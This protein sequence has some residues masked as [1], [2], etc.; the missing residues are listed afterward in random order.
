VSAALAF[1]KVNLALV[2]GPSL[3]GGKHEVLT[4]LQRVEL[5]DRLSLVPAA[6]NSV[7]GFEGDTLGRAAL[8]S[9]ASRVG[10]RTGW[11]LRIDK[12]I[13]VASGLGGGSSDAAAALLLAN[14]TLDSPLELDELTNLARALGADVPFFLRDGPQLG[15]GDG[16]VLS[17]LRLPSDYTVL[18]VLADGATKASTGAVYRAFDDRDGAAGFS[19][20]RA[21]LEQA[22]AG[23]SEALD[24]SS[25]PPNDLA[26]SP[27]A[28]ELRSL[29]AFR[30]DVSGAGPVVYGLF[31]ERAD[32]E[33]AALLLERVGRTW[34]T[35]PA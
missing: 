27:L 2:V 4:V 12:V 32:A 28:A 23:V 16:S 25:L 30:A 6:A 35:R 17:P 29:G 15:K 34:I 19:D 10:A 21:H 11:T 18:L 7:T 33:A 26:S 5:A 22:L 24:L 14:Q 8:D 3:P 31:G 1:A 9:L 13:P 20:R